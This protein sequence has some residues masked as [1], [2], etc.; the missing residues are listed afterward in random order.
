V[1]EVPPGLTIKTSTG[2]V[3]PLAGVETETF[4]AVFVDDVMVA[5]LPPKY[6]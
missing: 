1:L 5:A 6:T 2:P 4:I 3:D